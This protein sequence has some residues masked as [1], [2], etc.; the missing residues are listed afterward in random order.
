MSIQE[1]RVHFTQLALAV[2]KLIV[3]KKL[4]KNHLVRAL[5]KLF[6]AVA[7]EESDLF[8]LHRLYHDF[9]GQA[10]ELDWPDYL[11]SLVLEDENAFTQAAAAVG[12]E[13]LSS[14][15]KALAS[16]DLAVLRLL[17]TLGASRVKEA[18]QELSEAQEERK[19]RSLLPETPLSWPEWENAWAQSTGEH[20]VRGGG[21][22][23][24]KGNADK[25]STYERRELNERAGLSKQ[26][27]K[28]K[29]GS[30]R[31]IYQRWEDLRLQAGEYLRGSCPVE[32]VVEFLASYYC[33]TG[34]G[35][36]SR[37]LAFRWRGKEGQS[38][39]GLEGIV[40][41]DPVRV[42][43]LIGL[44]REL[45]ILAENTEYFLAGH[46]A[47]NVLLYGNRGT[48][49]SSAVKA[50]LDTYGEQG[51]RLIELAKRNLGDLPDVVR[52]LAGRPQKFILF[53]D[54]LSFDDGE[55]EYKNLKTVLEGGL[56]TKPPNVLIY[57]TSNRRHLIRENFAEREGD[58]VHARDT[59]EEK[60]SLADRFGITITFPS[61]DQKGYLQ[62]VQGLALQR[63][64]VVEEEELH[65]L[66][67]RWEMMHN[68][69]SG[70]TARQFVD[71]LEAYL[72]APGQE[73]RARTRKPVV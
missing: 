57:A 31:D 64:L 56:E 38:G 54:D 73:E 51:L 48:G 8:R 21:R 25:F 39:P 5:Q 33:K 27:T 59:V 62:I 10:V 17:G 16:Q 28:Q 65:R 20:P 71:Y 12:S 45:K 67:L 9:C 2:D 63:G 32:E 41:P 68:G 19:T 52:H 47:N 60:L 50:L 42:E 66:A 44:E 37:Y 30:G 36:L 23:G 40:N 6:W 46:H 55:P 3:Y 14:A 35:P 70:R 13:G 53:V 58:E 49:K 43:Q 69:R 15:M 34:Y 29:K 11:S 24:E 26:E 61:P 22:S 4:K 72:S 1:V 7:A 18:I